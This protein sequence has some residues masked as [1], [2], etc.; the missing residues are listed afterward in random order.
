MGFEI[1]GLKPG[2]HGGYVVDEV[3]R[4]KLPGDWSLTQVADRIAERIQQAAGKGR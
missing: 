1:F 2:E 3:T 4:E